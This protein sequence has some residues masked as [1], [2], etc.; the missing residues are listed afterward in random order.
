MTAAAAAA[1]VAIAATTAI[2]KHKQREYR[3]NPI[4]KATKKNLISIAHTHKKKDRM[5]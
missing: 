2:C 3:Y 4:Y 5:E 1:A